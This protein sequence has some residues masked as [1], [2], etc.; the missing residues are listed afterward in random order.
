[1]SGPTAYNKK[2]MFEN[3]F[4]RERIVKPYLDSIGADKL[5]QNPLP[6]Q[7]KIVPNKDFTKS[8]VDI[9]LAEGYKEGP[10]F[11]KGAK[12]CLMWKM[13]HDGFPHANWVIVRRPDESIINS[14][15]DTP[16]MRKN[17][18]RDE[19]QKWIDYHKERFYEL[20]DLGAIE[21]WSN[22]LIEG[23]FSEISTA[24]EKSGVNF[25]ESIAREFIDS[26]LW[27]H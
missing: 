1:M 16:F 27:T 17:T 25:R 15:M 2:G 6:D 18:T 21:I 20:K 26:T 22:R 3:S 8:I 5:G 7:S 10:I 14:C 13:W 23:D 11:Y 24:I 19:W 9:F 12:M 4:I